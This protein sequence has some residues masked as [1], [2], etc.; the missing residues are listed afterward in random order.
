VLLVGLTG[1]IGSGKSTVADLLAARGA[2]VV[3]AD[4]VARDVVEPGTP[5]LAALVERFGAGILAADGRL[6]RAALAAVAFADEASR[7]DLEAITH[8]AIGEEFLRR[9]A[10]APKG[11]IVVCDVPLLAESPPA[12]ARGYSVV[13]VVEAPLDV[14]L[15]RLEARGVPRAD[16]RQRVAAQASDEERRKIATHVLDNS[17]DRAHLERLVDELWS[18]LQRRRA[19]Q[20]AAQEHAA[21]DERAGAGGSG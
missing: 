8:P 7:K 18:D 5:A 9:M 12:Q 19:D 3:D 21:G 4:R 16:A 14:R 20:E 10:A 13:V 2:V 6:D 11:A 1:G 17:G 15:E